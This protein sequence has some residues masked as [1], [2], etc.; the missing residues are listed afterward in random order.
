MDSIFS[1]PAL[2]S[3]QVEVGGQTL[4]LYEFTS[5]LYHKYVLSADAMMA[6][7]ALAAWNAKSQK[8]SVVGSDTKDQQ[9]VDEPAVKS[10]KEYQNIYEERLK[11][12]DGEYLFIAMSLK[13]G[14]PEQ[15]VE[16]L[17]DDLKAN[18]NASHR[19]KMFNKVIELNGM[20]E[21]KKDTPESSSSTP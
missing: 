9:P 15:T 6:H 1:K 17:V 21:P 13:P 3:E 18:T 8:E 5:D 14:Y 10:D 16:Q 19:L 2:Q 20:L 12:H 4:T 7:D 11:V